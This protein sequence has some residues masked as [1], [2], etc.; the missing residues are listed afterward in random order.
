MAEERG[1]RKEGGEISRNGEE[2]GEGSQLK[3]RGR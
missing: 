2:E 3:D 1:R